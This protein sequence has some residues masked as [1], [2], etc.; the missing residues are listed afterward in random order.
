MKGMFLYGI[1]CTTDIWNNIREDFSAFDID[2]VSY[3]HEVTG[4][5]STAY[6]IARWVY[7]V[8]GSTCYDFVLGHSMGGVVALELAAKLKLKCG[9]ILLAETNLK[10]ADPF[11]RNLMTPAHMVSFGPQV[12]Q[13][14][15]AEAPYY[16]EE[17][18]R[19]LQED[20]DYTG[21][22]MDAGQAV[23]AVYGDR[24]QKD[25]PGRL[26]GL[27]LPEN[28]IEKI[29][30][31]FVEDACHMPMIENPQGFSKAILNILRQ[32]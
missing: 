32:P 27:C 6:D 23:Y 8:Y 7:S 1:Y 30:F 22:A 10:P 12:K 14:L 3:P 15:Q 18:K 5:A 28:V 21:L 26:S 9:R 13:M 25:Y 20:F 16:R 17:L 2:Y 31:S 24:G 11:Y 19:S 4:K 29:S